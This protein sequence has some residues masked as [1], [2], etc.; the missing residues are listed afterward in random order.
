MVSVDARGSELTTSIAA[1]RR[2]EMLMFGLLRAARN[3]NRALRMA[4]RPARSFTPELEMLENRQ[5]MSVWAANSTIFIAGTP[6]NDVASIRDV[7]QR[8]P[9]GNFVFT[10]YSVKINNET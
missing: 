4:A 3:G 1:P 2:K 7:I 6:G 10:G 8:T 9:N 5:L